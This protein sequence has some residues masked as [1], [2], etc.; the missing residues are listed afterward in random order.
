MHLFFK[1]VGFSEFSTNDEEKFIKAAVKK[2][3]E[4]SGKT[5]G[6]GEGGFSS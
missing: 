3:I 6:D 4:S 5:S 1:T 2:A